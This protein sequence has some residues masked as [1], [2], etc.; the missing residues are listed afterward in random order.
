M[1]KNTVKVVK[2]ESF[3]P[4]DYVSSGFSTIQPDSCFPNMILGNR[5]D[6][7][8]F[9]LRRNIAHNF[10]VDQRRQEV[11]FVSRDEAH[12]LYNTALKF[13]GKKAL[14][15]GCWMGWS[16]CHLALGGVELDVIDPMLAEQLFNES[17]TESLKLAGVKESVNLIP[18]YSPQKVEEI[19]N[20]FQRKWSLIFIDGHHEAPAP[21]ND[22]II[23]EQLAEPDALILFHDLA[24]PDVGQGLDYLKEKGWNTMVYQTM[25]IMGVAWRGNVE[26]VIHQPDAN[27]DWQL[28]PH[29][30]DYVVS[31]VSQTVGKDRLGEILKTLQPYTLLSKA[32]LFSLYSHVKQA[33]AYLFW[34]PQMLIRRSLK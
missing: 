3:P 24:S 29:L 25:Q 33:Y 1:N 8:W 27:I 9:Y 17:V 34:L 23:C 28:P 18:G 6:S 30:Q 14:E 12:I 22:A 19:A 7:L 32:Q 4:G 5:Y 11:G 2:N 13:Q 26:P 10:Y 20:Q 16:A 31:G 21:L 15:I